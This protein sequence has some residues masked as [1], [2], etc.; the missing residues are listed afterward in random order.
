MK[1]IFITVFTILWYCGA[2]FAAGSS[3]LTPKKA[4]SVTK[5]NA[6]TSTT[7]SGASLLGN[8]LGLVVSGVQLANEQKV[9]AAECE[10]T[11]SELTF[12][13]DLMKEWA[14]AGGRNPISAQERCGSAGD[15]A[16]NIRNGWD[17]CYEVYSEKEAHGAVWAGYP[18]AEKAEYCAD[19]GD[20]YSCSKNNKKVATNMWQ[21]LDAIQFDPER[22][23]TKAE[24]SR[25]SSLIE[26]QKN[27]SSG[28]MAQ[29]RAESFKGFVSNA[30][31]NTGQNANTPSIM[32]AVSTVVSQT[33]LGGINGITSVA[34]KLLDR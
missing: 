18:K 17:P 22:D 6:S 11:S 23:Y 29:K 30:I 3:V 14:Y 1:R 27:C 4:D 15:Y 10:P 21:L 33:G 31:N 25:A 34:T 8:A 32:E 9:L 2:S 28:K 24:A 26:K 19:Y 12:V 20:L 16:K 13:N 5:K 7:A